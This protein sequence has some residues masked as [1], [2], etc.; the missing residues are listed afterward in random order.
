MSL[1]E[2]TD[3]EERDRRA[4]RGHAD[5]TPTDGPVSALQRRVGNQAIERF[6]GRD[7]VAPTE[8]GDPVE[9]P[10][11]RAARSVLRTA[12]T[13]PARWAA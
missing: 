5:R 6:T 3:R 4:D 1:R 7:G 10:A 2:H 12:M 8:L 13:D 9:T 11:D